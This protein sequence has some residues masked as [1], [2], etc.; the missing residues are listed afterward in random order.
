M[1]GKAGCG[2]ARELCAAQA[3]QTRF[4]PASSTGTGAR[5]AQGAGGA[6]GAGNPGGAGGAGGAGRIPQ[7]PSSELNAISP[8]ATLIKTVVFIAPADPGRPHR[9]RRLGEKPESAVRRCLGAASGIS[10]VACVVRNAPGTDITQSRTTIFGAL[11]ITRSPEVHQVSQP[12]ADRRRSSPAGR[13]RLSPGSAQSAGQGRGRLRSG[14]L[15][16]PPSSTAPCTR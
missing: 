2:C 16:R 15:P 4:Q 12:P 11:G 10:K 13:P 3:P 1:D 8:R 7:P 14:C 6:G 5:N 9:F